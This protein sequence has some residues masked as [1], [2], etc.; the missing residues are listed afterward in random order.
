MATLKQKIAAEQKVRELLEGSDVPLPDEIEYRYT[1]I[2]LFWLKPKVVLV[3]DI[4][5]PPESLDGAAWDGL[6]EELCAQCGDGPAEDLGAEWRHES[7]DYF[8]VQPRD[9]S[10]E[11][12]GEDKR[13]SR[14]LAGLTY[15]RDS[16]SL[17]I[18]GWHCEPD[19][20]DRP[21][22]ETDTDAA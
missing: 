17:H 14:F 5:E 13:V 21:L 22:G 12:L 2:R 4:D 20:A 10:L 19:D 15:E 7:S 16:E 1:C 3:V 6:T 11:G 8:D 9:T 18:L